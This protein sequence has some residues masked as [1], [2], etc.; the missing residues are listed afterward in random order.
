MAPTPPANPGPSSQRRLRGFEPAA[1]LLKGRMRAAGEK[2]GFAVAR[3]LT[4]WDAVAGERL[5]AITLPVKVSYPRDGLGATLTLLVSPAH[6][7]EVQMAL[8]PLLDRVNGVYGY[9]AIARIALTQ[10]AA[11]G[12]AEGQSPFTPAPKPRPR[13]PDPAKLAQAMDRLAPLADPGL[14]GALEL[15]ARNIFTRPDPKEGPKT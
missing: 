1:G 5:A 2:R 3:L 13:A 6:G 9:R 12:F 4:E 15:M 14:R 8:P 11:T 7:P 10:T